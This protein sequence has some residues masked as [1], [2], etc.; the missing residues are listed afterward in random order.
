MKRNYGADQIAGIS[1]FWF[2]DISGGWSSEAF[3]ELWWFGNENTDNEI[4]ERFGQLH[5]S[6]EKGELDHWAETPEGRVALIVLL[7]QFSRNLYRGTASAFA[8]DPKSLALCLE[9]IRVRHDLDLAPVKRAFLYMPLMHSEDMRHHEMAASLY[10]ALVD[11]VDPSK[12]AEA[13]KMVVGAKLHKDIIAKFGRYPHR[14]RALGRL[15]SREEVDYL[16][17]DAET[18]GQD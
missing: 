11:L 1:D 5:T 10:S 14:N 7:D 6:A 15:S 3:T 8:A 9:G 13:E 16:N 18:F 2:G 4:L 17:A 12:K